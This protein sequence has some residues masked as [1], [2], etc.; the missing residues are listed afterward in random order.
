MIRSL[1][2]TG[3]TFFVLLM[4]LSTLGY[5]DTSALQGSPQRN[6]DPVPAAKKQ[7]DCI[8]NI[9]EKQKRIAAELTNIKEMIKKEAL[10][11]QKR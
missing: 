1:L 2:K 4:V 6:S 5:K 8:K 7:K 11:L 10:K 9:Q 3:F